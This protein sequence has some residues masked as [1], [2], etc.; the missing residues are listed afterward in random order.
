MYQ[1][2][3]VKNGKLIS[4]SKIT[5]LQL[6]SEHNEVLIQ[7][8]LR[9][10]FGKPLYE[11]NNYEDAYCYVIKATDSSNS[12]LLFEIY[13]GSGGCAIGGLGI[14][15]ELN[16]AIAEFKQ[17]LQTTEPEDFCY[18][19]YYMDAY[20]KIRCGIKNGKIFYEEIALEEEEIEKVYR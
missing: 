4:G 15:L 17:L 8:I 1:F 2:T 13:Q 3:S 14:N 16:K 18:E 11:T 19:G 9:R 10:L 5:N 12:S 6:F 20:V 7:G